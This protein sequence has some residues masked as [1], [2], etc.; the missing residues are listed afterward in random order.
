MI[1]FLNENQGAIITIA[2]VVLVIITAIYAVLTGL[3][4]RA[5]NTPEIA[6]YLKVDSGDYYLCVENVGTG[7]A[8]DLEFSDI[9]FEFNKETPLERILYL[10]KGIKYLA[11]GNLMRDKIRLSRTNND[12]EEFDKALIGIKVKYT[13]LRGVFRKMLKFRDSFE[14]RFHEISSDKKFRIKRY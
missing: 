6:I 7:G 4:V 9:I 14:I 1:E 8:R 11:P 3:L 13:R 12:N 2:T 5:T 10:Q